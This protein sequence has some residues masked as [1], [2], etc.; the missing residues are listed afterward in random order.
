MRASF[1]MK[2]LQQLPPVPMSSYVSRIVT[3]FFFGILTPDIGGHTNT[4]RGYLPT[5][6]SKLELQLRTAAFDEA[7]DVVVS[8]TDKHPLQFV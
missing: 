8:E 5:L 4:E 2:C 3:L 6:A 1:S 7:F